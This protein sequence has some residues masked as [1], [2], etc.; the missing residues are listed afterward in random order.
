M[1]A[2]FTFLN[3]VL[4]GL[5]QYTFNGLENMYVWDGKVIMFRPISCAC[6]IAF[7]ATL[8]PCPSKINNYLLLKVTLLGTYF[9][10]KEQNSLNKKEVIQAFFCI[11]M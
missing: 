2:F 3:V 7:K 9:L 4:N 10:K 11:A 5:K 6:D 1:D 8:L